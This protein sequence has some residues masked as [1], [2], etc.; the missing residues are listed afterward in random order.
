MG[1]T[2]GREGGREG[3]RPADEIPVD[4]KTSLQVKLFGILF[5]LISLLFYCSIRTAFSQLLSS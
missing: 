5:C 1:L 4:F 3:G 2:A